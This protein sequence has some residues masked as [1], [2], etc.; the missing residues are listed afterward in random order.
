MA[1]EETTGAV[2]EVAIDVAAEGKR[3]QMIK[4]AVIILIIA[5]MGFVVWKYVL[6]K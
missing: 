5:V 1:G 6:K 2:K 3:K 4:I